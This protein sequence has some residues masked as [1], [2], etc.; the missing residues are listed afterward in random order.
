LALIT[1]GVARNGNGEE[2]MTL[3]WNR[4]PIGGYITKHNGLIIQVS[5][6]GTTGVSVCCITRDADQS[7]VATGQHHKQRLARRD[8]VVAFGKVT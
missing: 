1:V 4:N 6:C 8:A 7:V 3:K 5:K 2:A